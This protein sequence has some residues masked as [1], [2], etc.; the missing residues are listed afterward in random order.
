VVVGQECRKRVEADVT[1]RLC[2]F[3]LFVSKVRPVS[4]QGPGAACQTPHVRVWRVFGTVKIIKEH[5]VENS[6]LILQTS[7]D[8]PLLRKYLLSLIPIVLYRPT[9]CNHDV[10]SPPLSSITQEDI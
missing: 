8:S 3:S 6:W 1:T 4:F 9:L 10:F 7:K 5:E 2:L